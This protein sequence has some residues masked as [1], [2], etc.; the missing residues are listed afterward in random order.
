MSKKNKGLWRIVDNFRG[1]KIIWMIALTLI[2]ISILV[3][4]SSTP[5]LAIQLHSTRSA[6]INKQVMV[7]C[8]GLGLIIFCYNFLRNIDFLRK[9]SRF[10]FALSFVL[11]LCLVLK[12]DTKLVRAE[13]INGAVRTLKF[14]KIPFQLHV[15]EFVKL[16]MVLY[17]A[18]ACQAFKKGEFR[19]ARRLA[20]LP[21]L[22]FMKK[23]TWQMVF[24]IALPVLLVTVM[25]LYGSASS[26]MFIGGIMVITVLLGGAVNL[27]QGL[28]IIA[29]GLVL[30]GVCVVLSFATNGKVFPRIQTV[31]GRLELAS[32]NKEEQ[33]VK[34]LEDRENEHRMDQFREAL[35]KYKQP[36][37]AKVAISEGSF[38]LGKGPGHSTQRYVVPIMFED[39]MFSFIVE[40]Y[41]ILGALLIIILYATLLARGLI[42]VKSC[43]E[44]YSKIVIAGLI[45]T[46]SG[47]AMMHMLINVD[48]GL[49]TG[50][51]LPMLSHGASSFIA[52]S[53]A[54]GII[55]SISRMVK[56]RVEKEVA[57][58][59][60]IIEPGDEVR[61]GLDDLDRLDAMD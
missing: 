26:A 52:F 10:G 39:Y 45:I 60:P 58:I 53:I 3:I 18:W 47:Q 46:I 14:Y 38:L 24:F 12:V 48:I 8:A 29:G 25:V 55:L 54:F 19:L 61:A 21:H 17:I 20:A 6:I 40:E 37:S 16:F 22:S 2:G 33:L 43:T 9:I 31:M 5:L 41:G 32:G 30:V 50:Q 1:D 59:K 7:A 13:E 35:D 49:L 34:I 51:T 57:Q 11:L 36:I 15:Y 27:K 44:L 56:E 28:P 4:S 42:L 23:K